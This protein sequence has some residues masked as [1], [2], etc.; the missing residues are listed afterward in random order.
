MVGLSGEGRFQIEIV[1]CI[2]MPNHVHFL[3]FLP[4]RA[5]IRVA[6]TVGQIVGAYKSLV[7][8]EWRKNCAGENREMHR[9]WQRNYYEHV[10]RNDHDLYETRKYIAE[11][12]QR[13]ITKDER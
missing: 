1:E 2:V 12:P 5:T 3:M 6:P 10:I 4:E 13:W 7:T 8:Y 11:N 9:I